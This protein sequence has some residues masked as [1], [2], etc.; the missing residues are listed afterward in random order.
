MDWFEKLTGFREEHQ[1]VRRDLEVG[2]GRLV[3]RVNG[4]SYGVG[5]LEVPSLEEL[6]VRAAGLPPGD[7]RLRVSVIVGDVREMHTDPAYR[8]ALFQVASQFNLLEMTSP[9]ITPEHGVTRYQWDHTQG[10]A[11]AMAAG[12]ATIYRNYFV[13]VDRQPGQ[14][15]DR[16]IDCLRDVGEVLGNAGGKLW[17]MR[18]GYAECRREGLRTIHQMITDM[19]EAELDQLRA[20]L[21]IGLHW[22]VEVTDGPTEGMQIVSQAFCSALPVAY[23]HIPRAEW[24]SFATL[25]L[26]ATYEATLLAARLTTRDGGR[27]LVLLTRV[28][29]GAFGNDALWIQRATMRALSLCRDAPLDVCLVARNSPDA[30]HHALVEA[31]Q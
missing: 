10:P 17:R 31:F 26:E 7:G 23:S 9:D 21:R 12:A 13:E 5:A 1:R 2:D 6:R 4:C 30:D 18:N 22:N 14:T 20:K 19:G 25:V 3:S 8:G 16:Q 27:G 11:C 29:G 28:G 15:A 24:E